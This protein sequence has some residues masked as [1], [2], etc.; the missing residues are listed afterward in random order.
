MQFLKVNFLD[1]HPPER[2]VVFMVDKK[3]NKY[4][5]SIHGKYIDTR[6]VRNEVEPVEWFDYWLKEF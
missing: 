5:G 3:G 4:A 2:Q 6:N 1:E